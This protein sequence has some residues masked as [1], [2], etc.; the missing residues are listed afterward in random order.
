MK[1]KRE[2]FAEKMNSSW[3]GRA[4]QQKSIFRILHWRLKKKKKSNSKRRNIKQFNNIYLPE[5]LSKE[6]NLIFIWN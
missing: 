6:I 2:K 3:R 5:V 4:Q 1:K